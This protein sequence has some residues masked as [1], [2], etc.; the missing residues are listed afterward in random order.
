MAKI[1]IVIGAGAGDEGKGIITAR[2]AKKYKNKKTLILL[3]NGGSQR[4]HTVVTD[5][6]SHTFK[7]FGSGTFSGAVTCF[8]KNFILNP[9]QFCKEALELYKLDKHLPLNKTLYHEN[10]LWSTPFDMMAN[11]IIQEQEWTGTCGMGI[12]ETMLRN[13]HVPFIPIQVFTSEAFTKDMQVK[14]LK[15]I[16]KYYEN[17]RGVKPTS[18]FK[19]AWESMGLIDH[20]IFDCCEFTRFFAKP[21]SSVESVFEEFDNVIIENGQGLL[22]SDEGKDDPEKTPSITGVGS[23]RFGSTESVDIHYVTRPYLTRHGSKNWQNK[24]ID[25]DLNKSSE[26]NIYNEFQHD[27][28]YNDLD[29]FEL[30]DRITKDL[31]K[32]NRDNFILEV[33]HCD[34][35]DRESEFKKFFETCNFY[36]S[37][38][39]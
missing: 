12:W 21:I 18:K 1:D 17:V 31:K 30:K 33:T 10:C 36:G 26:T 29:L 22:L 11:Q 39:V 35:L 2:L 16:K 9:M 38:K 23:T 4:G 32:T 25:C 15:G 34:E 7:H 6:Y 14:Y 19:D 20:F 27:F 8:D 13:K 28:L 37:A 3:P 5:E 24:K